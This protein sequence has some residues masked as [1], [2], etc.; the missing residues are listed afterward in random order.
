MRKAIIE[1]PIIPCS[2]SMSMGLELKKVITK[3]STKA[4]VAKAMIILIMIFRMFLSSKIIAVPP[5]H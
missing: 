4:T 2:F 5:V 3:Y 1:T